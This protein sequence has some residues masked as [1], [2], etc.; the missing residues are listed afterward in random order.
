[1]VADRDIGKDINRD[2][3]MYVYTNLNRRFYICMKM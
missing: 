3:A 2:M 1:M